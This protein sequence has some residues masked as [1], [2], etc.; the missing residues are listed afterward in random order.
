MTASHRRLRVAWLGHRSAEL[1][2]GMATYSNE[3]TARLR[4]RGLNVTFFTHEMKGLAVEEDTVG[5]ASRALLKPLVFSGRRAKRTLVD[6]L[7]A[8]DFDLVHASFWFSSLDFDLPKTCRDAGIPLVATFHVAFDQRFSVWGGITAATYRL[9][10]PVLARCDRVI[11]FGEAQRT[12]LLEMGVPEDVLRILPN[13]VDVDRYA[14][15]PSD[16]K[17]RL[18]AG[19]RLFV[20]MGRVDSEKNVDVLLRAFIAN[21]PPPT[22]RLAI[23]GHGTERRRLQKQYRDPRIVFTG[24]VASADDRIGILR[25]ADAF[26]LPSS[27]EGLSLSMLEAMACG[28]ATVATDVGGDGDALR[29]A[30]IVLDP[31]DLE[32]Q[33]SLVLRSFLELPWIMG[34]LGEAARQRVLE[35]FALERN[36]DAL[37]ALYAEVLA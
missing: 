8:H 19:E 2:G 24:H 3:I 15:G 6:R 22:T 21:D 32:E 1:G 25:A 36:I 5:L 10:A 28:T 29:G 16:W 9:Y 26:F 30:G 35:R 31:D 11:V 37:T 13:G 12:Q 33:L 23:V 20:Y 34:P 14:P 7:Q 18:G 27:V 17:T 4:A